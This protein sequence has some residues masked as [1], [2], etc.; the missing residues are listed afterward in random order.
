MFMAQPSFFLDLLT[1]KRR[2]F[3]EKRLKQGTKVN[4]MK[5]IRQAI[6]HYLRF[7]NFF[8]QKLIYTHS[9]RQI[10]WLYIRASQANGFCEV[11]N[12]TAE[13]F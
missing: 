3:S 4:S 2:E 1:L 5:W 8:F 9:S 7:A 6:S 12:Y 10:R 13:D 11:N